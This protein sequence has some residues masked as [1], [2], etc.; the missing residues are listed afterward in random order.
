MVN[1]KHRDCFY[2]QGNGGKFTNCGY[3]LVTGQ[4]RGCPAGDCDKYISRK[5]AERIGLNAESPLLFQPQ[6]QNQ[7]KAPPKKNS[8]TR[9]PRNQIPANFEAVMQRF[10]AGEFG[11]ILAAR[12]C[13]MVPS[14]F[15]YQV[16]KRKGNTQEE[17]TMKNQS[18]T[19]GLSKEEAKQHGL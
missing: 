9:K 10:L 5:E 19:K 4:L 3:L 11:H 8:S 7:K 18:E 16:K 12:E 6:K 14:T 2:I 1:C 13:G 17:E 15:L